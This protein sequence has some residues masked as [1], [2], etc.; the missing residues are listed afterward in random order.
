MTD[1][2]DFTL[3][4]EMIPLLGKQPQKTRA[5]SS[6]KTKAAQREAKGPFFML[7]EAFLAAVY[8]AVGSRQELM[9]AMLIYRHCRMSGFKPTKI[10]NTLLEKW[11]IDRHTK[12]RVLNK[13]EALG[14]ITQEVAGRSAPVVTLKS[15]RVEVAEEEGL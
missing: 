11:K 6:G 13:L 9:T 12:Y 10:T 8:P 3:P 4:P 15:Q 1:I 5:K 14:L 2:E 7:S